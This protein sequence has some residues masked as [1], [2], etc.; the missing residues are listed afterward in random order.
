M[1]KFSSVLLKNLVTLIIV[2][3]IGVCLIIY[4]RDTANGIK[5]GFL[6]LGNS[7]IPALFPF[8]VLSSYISQ[9]N[10]TEFLCKL[11]EK[12][13]NF[14]FR[15]SAYGF[16]PFILGLLGGYP[17]GAKTIAEIYKDNKISE[18]DAERLFYW[19]INPSPAFAITAVGT[20]M[21]NNTKA[22][23]IMYFSCISASLTVGFLCRFIGNGEIREIKRTQESPNKNIFVKSVSKGS[24]AM[25]SVCGWVLTFCVLAALCQALKLP[26]TLTLIIKSV[27]EVTTG[28]ENAV[29]SGLSLPVI[30]GI[31]DF[32]GFAVICQC[33][34]YSTIC[35]TEIKNLLCSRLINASLSAI[36]CSLLLKIFPQCA[37]VSVVLGSQNTSFTLYHSIG[38]SII[39]LT[40]CILLI[41]EVDNRKKVC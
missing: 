13:F 20:F 15:T 7:L 26:D 30:A 6:V 35:K 29:I 11:V 37:E 33:A 31:L 16:I 41:L 8:M 18:N 17:I 28:C 25:L 12:P 38:A 21:L 4:P 2:C 40:M 14:L 36:Y 27:G 9:S 32:G 19:C 1:K 10:I 24:E 23:F 3:A 22:G 39:L 5:N 34:T